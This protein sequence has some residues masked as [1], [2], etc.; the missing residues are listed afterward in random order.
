MM[1]GRGWRGSQAD[2]EDLTETGGKGIVGEYLLMAQRVTTDDAVTEERQDASALAAGG[3][4]GWG[5]G[6]MEDY[7]KWSAMTFGGPG[8]EPMM[9]VLRTT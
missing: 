9:R 6:R 2:G 7:Q 3:R 8:V 5:W 4:G 1:M